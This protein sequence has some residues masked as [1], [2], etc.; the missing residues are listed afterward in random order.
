MTY[1]TV[2]YDD[3]YGL[4][5]FLDDAYAT[6]EAAEAAADW[7]NAHPSVSMMQYGIQYSVH[8]H[9]VPDILLSSFV[10]PMT[11]EEYIKSLDNPEY[12]EMVARERQREYEESQYYGEED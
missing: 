5:C 1:Y 6:R 10:P 11:D 4:C 2:G 9:V 8:E 7:H 12:H 3:G